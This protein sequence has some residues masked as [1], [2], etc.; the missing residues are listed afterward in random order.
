MGTGWQ[1]NTPHEGRQPRPLWQHPPASAETW[2]PESSR[3]KVA[4]QRHSLRASPLARV[5]SLS[6]PRL[7]LMVRS[8]EVHHTVVPTR[9]MAVTRF[10]WSWRAQANRGDSFS[11]PPQVNTK[12]GPRR[13]P[14]AYRQTLLEL[15]CGK[16]ENVD[17]AVAHAAPK[18]P[19]GSRHAKHAFGGHL[20]LLVWAATQEQQ[21]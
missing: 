11:A 17:V 10:E 13:C 1:R 15:E 18:L 8:N 5:R 14:A 12:K 7:T 6:Q 9:A 2:H 19:G 21:Q 3:P 20:L 4:S 16:E